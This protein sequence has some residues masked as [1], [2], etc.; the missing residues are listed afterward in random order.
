MSIGTR[1]P[2]PMGPSCLPLLGQARQVRMY[3]PGVPGGAVD[4]ATWSK[5]PPF[6]SYVTKRAVFAHCAGLAVKAVSIADKV[7][8][9]K[10]EG[11]GGWSE[12]TMDASTQETCGRFPDKAS[13]TKSDGKLWPKS[14][15]MERR[16][17]ILKI[18]EVRQNIVRQNAVKNVRVR[19][20]INFPGNTASLKLFRHRGVCQ[21]PEKEGRFTPRV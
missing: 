2:R 4:G 11:A 7:L 5:N 12:S 15:L 1:K 3:S 10:S 21:A 14:L 20:R 9:P 8:S 13:A 16:R 19:R 17:G 18:L 6:S